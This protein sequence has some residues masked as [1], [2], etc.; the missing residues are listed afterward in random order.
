MKLG[1][2]IKKEREKRGLS[3]KELGILA[4]RITAATISRIENGKRKGTAPETLSS[5][6]TALKVIRLY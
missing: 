1:E 6:E 2:F 5:L 3:Q 4:G